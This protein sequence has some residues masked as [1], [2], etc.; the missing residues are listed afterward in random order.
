MLKIVS[1]A[2][3]MEL[4]SA[5]FDSKKILVTKQDSDANLCIEGLSPVFTHRKENKFEP[6]FLGLICIL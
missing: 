2:M 5:Q 3:I 1:T 4:P 6:Q